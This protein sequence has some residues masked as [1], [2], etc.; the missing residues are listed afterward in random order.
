MKILFVSSE[1]VPYVK[2]GGLADV[3]SALP[4]ELKKRGHDVRIILPKYNQ[5]DFQKF[6]L[7]PGSITFEIPNFY[8]EAEIE[9]IKEPFSE[10][11]TYFV[12]CDPYYARE[13]IY[14]DY[15]DNAERFIFFSK[16]A[17]EL[18]KY[19]D[20]KPDIIHCN[21]W[22]TGIL[23]ALLKNIYCQNPLYQNIWSLITVHNMTYQGVFPREKFNC[24]GLPE[25]LYNYHALEY[26][27]KISLLKAG[28]VYADIIN[29]VSET[30]AKEIQ[31]HEFGW[32]LEGVLS[33]RKSD[34]YGI[35][36][37]IDYEV[38]DPR[39]DSHIW[40]NYDENSL[41]KKQLNKEKLQQECHLPQSDVPI[42]GIISRL[43]DQK[44]FDLIEL[45]I[46]QIMQLDLQFIL[47]GMGIPKYHQL[48]TL[49]GDYYFEKTAIYFKFD[50]I[51]AHK[52]EA[53]AD[54]FLMPSQFEPCGLNQLI[55]LRY[56]TIPIVRKTGGLADSIIDLESSPD[57]LGIG[58]T[59][60][61]YDSQEL[62][63]KIKKA[64][65][66]YEDKNRR[67]LIIKR[68]M[69]KDFSWAVSAQ[70]YEQLYEKALEKNQF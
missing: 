5:I 35:L 45:I 3:S 70:K 43:V 62:L 33:E 41:E 11:I 47:V 51:L 14:N 8:Y 59:F 29:T 2:T 65:A 69:Q 7:E 50:D 27:G 53:G 49:I 60:D 68:C 17:L 34:L 40:Y 36:N 9:K 31:T 12:K 38:W 1:A 67:Q 30:Y 10:L 54:F 56:G 48:F 61:N 57:E 55:S 28:L 13:E 23:P 32:G 20:W 52:I 44:G 42:I 21:D 63:E 22:Q 16:A 39:I 25:E 24:T 64:V 58:F 26:W 66:F 6:N 18:L 19:I 46:D 15:E 4:K 37:G